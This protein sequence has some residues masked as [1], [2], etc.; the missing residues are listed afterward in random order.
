VCGVGS[1][2]RETANE[3]ELSGDRVVRFVREPNV[4]ARFASLPKKEFSMSCIDD[5]ENGAAALFYAYS[6]VRTHG[7]TASEVRVPIATVDTGTQIRARMLK[8]LTYYLEGDPI[9]GQELTDIRAGAG[10]LD[11]ATDLSRL[12]ALYETHKATIKNDPLLYQASDAKEALST[13][14]QILEA[15]GDATKT[16]WMDLRNRCFTLVVASLEEVCAAGKFLFRHDEENLARFGTL[17]ALVGIG[18]GRPKKQDEVQ[19][20]APVVP[21]KG[22]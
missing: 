18:G 21:Q 12:A 6:E 16:R 8:L 14:R 4:H 22:G 13:A 1:G 2:W 11:L 10:Y 3:L 20:A 17:R 5:L 15:L 9:V 19:P 7:A